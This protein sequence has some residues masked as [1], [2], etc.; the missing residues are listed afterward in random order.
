MKITMVK[1]SFLFIGLFLVNNIVGQNSTEKKDYPF[2][3]TNLA[4]DQRV[5]DLINRLTLEEKALQMVHNSPAIERLGIP[6]YNWWNEALHGVGRSGVATVFPQAI[7]LGATFDEELIREVAS[8]ISDEARATHNTA[9]KNGYRRQYSGLTFWTPNIN[10]F[11]DPRWGRGQE[12]YGEDPYL[13]SILGTAFVKGLQGDHP[14]YLKTAAAAKHY[15]VH[16]GPEKLRH[17]FNAEASQKDLWETYLPA[18]EALVDADVETIMCA[19]NSTNGEPCCANKYL[20][21][22]VLRNQWGFKGHIVSDCWAL[23]DFYDGHNVVETPAESAALAIKSGVNLN[24][25]NTYPALPEAV[26]RGLVIEKEIDEQLAI[27]L[28]T[29][30]KLGLFDP[31]ENNPFANLSEKDLNTEK[32]RKLAREVAQKSIVMLKNNGVLPLKNDLSKYFITGPNATSIEILLGNYHGINPDLVTILEGVAGAIE[33][34]SQM[35]YR[36][37]T[38]LDRPNANPQDWASPNAGNSDATIAVLGISGVLEGEEGESIASETAGD[39][40]N[41]NIPQN[42]IDYLEKLNEAAGENPL[43][44]VITG[45]SPMNLEK[46]HEL[47]DAVLLTW[48]PGEE[49]GNAVADVIFGKVSPSGRLPITFPKSLDDLPPYEDYTMNGRTYKYMDAVPMYPFGYGLSY[50]SFEYSDLKLSQ[51]KVKKG[52]SLQAS[53][54]VKNTG[55]HEAEE[56]VQLYVS[57]I[58]TSVKAPKYQ[59]YGVKRVKLA[60][61]SSESVKFEITPKM[62]ELVNNNGERVLEKGEFKIHVGGSTPHSRNTELGMNPVQQATFLFN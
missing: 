42:Q 38:L 56:V 23:V 22:E 36:Q 49:G 26:E 3:D 41:Y 13:T 15:A 59:L 1:I 6:E 48:Y 24:C 33:P 53:V 46:V 12:T 5:E 28:K 37:G 9:V 17:E 32:H 21:Q 51:D 7:G 14:K 43:I 19:Y 61:K 55:K 39:R 35:Q 45:G 27:L 10:I 30:F 16:S 20:L 2:R 62:M 25:G 50:T 34:Q 4:I 52:K 31:M 40:I 8:V 58:K 18:F 60:P 11:R 57:D 47:A 29:K 44:V 54:I